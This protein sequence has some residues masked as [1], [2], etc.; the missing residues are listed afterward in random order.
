LQTN[1]GIFISQS[2]YACDLIHCFH[3]DD[4]KPTPYPFQF[5]VKLVSTCTSPKV[6][7]TLYHQLVVRLLYLN[8][9]GPDNFF[10]VGLVSWY[11]KT[12]HEIH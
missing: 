7:A 6:Y 3:M 9:T 1:E 10:V 11:M 12:L 5:G 8:H 4:Y 2:K